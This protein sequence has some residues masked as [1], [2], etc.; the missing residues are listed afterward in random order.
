MSNNVDCSLAGLVT[1]SKPATDLLISKTTEMQFIKVRFTDSYIRYTEAEEI[2]ELE[3]S[4]ALVEQ[5]YNE[6]AFKKK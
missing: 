5:N 2:D 4:I 6:G 1:E 3:E